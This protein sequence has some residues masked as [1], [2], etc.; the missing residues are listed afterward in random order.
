MKRSIFFTLVLVAF[1]L[2][3]TAIADVPQM[4]NYQGRLT[5][6]IGEAIVDGNYIIKF[7]IYNAAVDG[8]ELWT[9]GLR[10][11]P[12]SSGL[13][14]YILGDST[15]FPEGLFGSDSPTYLGIKIGGDNELPNRIILI[16]VP[17]AMHSKLSDSSKIAATIPDHAITTDKIANG[18]ILFEDIGQNGA[19]NGQVMKWN[20]STWTASPDDTGNGRGSNW[21]VVDSVLYTNAFWGLARGGAQNLMYGDSIHTMVNLGVSCSTGLCQGYGWNDYRYLTIGGGYGNAVGGYF[22]TVA[23]GKENKIMDWHSTIGGGNS[24]EMMGPGGT[25]CGGISNISNGGWTTIGG[26]TNNFIAGGSCGVICGGDSNEIWAQYSVV[27]GGRKNKISAGDILGALTNNT[28]ITGK[29][30]G[31]IDRMDNLTFVAV[32]RDKAGRAMEILRSSPIKG[33]K[34]TARMNE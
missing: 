28:G 34:F 2:N 18:T 33:R 27:G 19:A 23:G 17:Y 29:D 25:I 3:S 32:S 4:I 7:T 6:T 20:G 13:F 26:G 31:K 21:S 1:I 24:N 16:S 10:E 14:N 30:I 9:S 12:V 5:D 8:D 22:N 15:A 11:V